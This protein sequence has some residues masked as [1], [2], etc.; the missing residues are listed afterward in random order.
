MTWPQPEAHAGDAL[1]AL[2]DG[3]L[4]GPETEAVEQHLAQCPPCRAELEDVRQARSILRELPAV[5]PPF[6]AIDRARTRVR[7]R[8]TGRWATA[9][10]GTAAAAWIVV[11]G[12]LTVPGKSVSPPVDQFAAAHAATSVSQSSTGSGV[13][14]V[15]GRPST[16]QPANAASTRFVPP[17]SAPNPFQLPDSLP[18]GFALV[19]AELDDNILQAVY[20]DGTRLISLFEQAGHADWSKLPQGER[21][22]S[23]GD[24]AWHGRAHGYDIVVVERSGIVYTLIASAPIQTALDAAG[25]LPEP[26]SPSVGDRLRAA[27]RGLLDAFSFG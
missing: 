13:S 16:G 1:S 18:G 19:G 26:G 7:R 24:K 4:T 10:L 15:M 14:A 17:D 12:V 2:V 21:M 27:G 22:R 25:D 6:G 23:S 11:L 20:S 8:G 9:S 3:E 5:E